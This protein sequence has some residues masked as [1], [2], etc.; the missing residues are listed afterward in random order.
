VATGLS[1]APGTA[2]RASF[3]A[4]YRRLEDALWRPLVGLT[5][6]DYVATG[7]VTGELF[8]RSYSR[9][10]YA[11]STASRLTPGYGRE[12]TNRKGYTQE[13]VTLTLGAGGSAFERLDWRA[14]GS[15]MDWWERFPDRE[16]AVQDPTP[17][18]AEPLQD[19]G[20]VIVRA[21]GLGR[22]DLLVGARWM[23]GTSL[24]ARL[25]WRLEAALT[26]NARDGFPI[27]YLQ[28][29][30][31][32]DP[33]AGSKSVL[34]APSVDTYRLPSLVLADT[35][36][37]RGFGLGPGRLTVSLD[38]FNLANA[39]TELQVARDVELASF[40]RTREIVRPRIFRLG[41]SWL[42]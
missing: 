10:F 39:G 37:A 27:P 33:T 26:V 20:R 3:E 18:D 1:W 11:P 19:F 9:A 6:A 34:V 41:V 30:S 25:P 32:G 8:G 13:S 5:S 21:G 2:L 23:A 14:W 36:L 7:A 24:L 28:V 22:G 42:F 12:L 40:D 15:F 35:R 29:G 17:L 38:V 4:S 31:T 16:R